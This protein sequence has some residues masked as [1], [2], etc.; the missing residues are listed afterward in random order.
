[1]KYITSLVLLLVASVGMAQSV[2]NTFTSGTPALAADVNENFA[3]VDAR[4]AS[5]LAD[6]AALTAVVDGLFADITVEETALVE[7]EFFAESLC[8]PD[9]IAISANCSCGGDGTTINFGVLSACLAGD[10]GAGQQGAAA[11]C[12]VDFFFDPILALPIAE[13]TATCLG[14]T[15]VDGTAAVA[16]KLNPNAEL[17]KA[18]GMP[19][20]MQR[21]LQSAKDR[22]AARRN[23]VSIQQ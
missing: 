23:L 11:F 6:G 20:S 5:G 22:A 9:T 8:P 3:D 18:M 19:T 14:A 2:P 1:M 16:G 10:D 12:D 17:Q 13:V 4:I 7:G 21:Q 15:K